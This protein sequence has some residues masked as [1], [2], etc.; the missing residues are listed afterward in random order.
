MNSLVIQNNGLVDPHDLCLIGSSTKRGDDTKIGMFGSG[1]K[2]ALAWFLRNEIDIRIFSGSNEIVIDYDMV[3]HRDKPVR[4]LTIDG[5]QTSITAQMGPQWTGWMAIREI[6]SNAIDEGGY[7]IN[8]V[9]NVEPK[10]L[11]DDTTT[12]YIPVNNDLQNVVRNYEHY[13]AFDRKETHINNKGRVFLKSYKGAINIYRKGIRC[14]DSKSSSKEYH[15][16]LDFDL[17]D[18]TINESRVADWY[19]SKNAIYSLVR[20]GIPANILLQCIREDRLPYRPSEHNCEQVEIL[21][22]QGY[23]FVSRIEALFMGINTLDVDSI[24]LNDGWY[25][26]LVERGIITSNINVGDLMFIE[27]KKLD[28][29]EVTYHLEGIGLDNITLISGTFDTGYNDVKRIDNH[30]ILFRDSLKMTSKA[31]AVEAMILLDSSI[32]E[33]IFK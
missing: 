29:T 3:I 30:T 19:D 16:K 13:F 28:L 27:T 15:S 18:I 23:H 14:F 11:T 7:E 10:G 33:V 6:V 12:I 4:V 21:V 25:K 24:I 8:T 20:A 26:D 17:N 22:A 32:L 31:M 9:F 1:W 2:Y 5:K